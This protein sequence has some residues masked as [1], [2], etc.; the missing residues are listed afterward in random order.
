MDSDWIVVVDN[1]SQ[2]Y[3]VVLANHHYICVLLDLVAG[4]QHG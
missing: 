3:T 1:E 4:S 2:W